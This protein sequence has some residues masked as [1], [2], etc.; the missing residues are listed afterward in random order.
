M[1]RSNKIIVRIAVFVII[2]A[3]LL[4]GGMLVM[5]LIPEAFNDFFTAA[6]AICLIIQVIA[7]T[8]DAVAY[9]K[10]VKSIK[11]KKVKDA[12]EL[13]DKKAEVI[14]A[15]YTK[16][17]KKT[18]RL[19]RLIILYVIFAG[20]TAAFSIFILTKSPTIYVTLL[21]SSYIL[22]NIIMGIQFFE[23]LN[24]TDYISP[25]DYPKLHFIA[26]KARNA[27][28]VKGK[29]RI[30]FYS[31]GGAGVAKVG[32]IISLQLDPIILTLLR[33]EELYNILLHEMS[34][35]KRGH[36]YQNKFES[37]VSFLAA[38]DIAFFNFFK[39]PA[40]VFAFNATIFSVLSSVVIEKETDLAMSEYGNPETAANALFKIQCY[41]FFESKID[42]LFQESYFKSEECPSVILKKISNA[43]LSKMHENEAHW[44]D[45]VLKEL[46]PRNA[47]HPIF[48]SRLETLGV[49]TFELT[50]PENFGEYREECNK[51]IEEAERK[52]FEIR[53]TD[54]EQNRSVY[55]LK[56]LSIV[57][58]WENEGKPCDNIEDMRAVLDA[59]NDICLYDEALL[60]AERIIEKYEG[61]I[62]VHA[63]YIRGIIRLAYDNEGGIDDIY[64]AM[65]Q[66]N[67]YIEEG[68][69]LIG[70]FCC[71]HGLEKRREEY[72][73]TADE[74][75]QKNIDTEG[76]NSLTFKDELSEETVLSD[77][78]K[79]RNLEY[80]ISIGE[81]IIEG[82]WLVRKKITEDF[83][84]STYV[85]EF[86]QDADGDTVEDVMH[87]V[88][89]YLDSTPEIWQYSLFYYD[90]VT[91]AALK[92]LPECKVY[93]K[94]TQNKA[95]QNN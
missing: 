29:I 17:L 54:Y 48:R 60:F 63:K 61:G 68:L 47:S 71:T 12:N 33:E 22:L 13:L 8:A 20:L 77:E 85:M 7:Y 75:F 34:H 15:D 78:I 41:E 9:A 6:A 23:P 89:I 28:G 65:K 14:R 10:F 31:N 21:S 82:I 88:F 92:H 1:K 37:F 72:R 18:L 67:N 39:F 69:Q 16:A 36:N 45:L 59:L 27:L 58:K 43:F 11:A 32:K 52:L 74:F 86:S 80:F 49:E 94:T 25:K 73:K 84:S 35:I 2:F 26:E 42:Y 5:P 64:D 44:R 30:I 38:D 3:G 66:N 81:E 4:A 19:K 91:A 62:S 90:S 93:S 79:S 40:A 87:K 51:G 76:I 83:Y 24:L 57:E 55:Y 50:E 95:E 56:P 53:K 46:Q 70:K